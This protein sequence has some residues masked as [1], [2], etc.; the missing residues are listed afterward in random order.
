MTTITR[1][2]IIPVGPWLLLCVIIDDRLCDG[3][4]VDDRLHLASSVS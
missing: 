4:T 2:P 3:L 1:P